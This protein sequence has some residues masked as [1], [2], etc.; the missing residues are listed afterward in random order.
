MSFFTFRSTFKFFR[1]VLFAQ[2]Y[3]RPNCSSNIYAIFSWSLPSSNTIDSKSLYFLIEQISI[4]QE[5][6]TGHRTRATFQKALCYRKIGIFQEDIPL[7][8]YPP[9]E[10]SPCRTDNIIQGNFILF[11]FNFI[12]NSYNFFHLKNTSMSNDKKCEIVK[13][14]TKP[15]ASI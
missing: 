7:S 6:F 11:F 9:V 3:G 15:S 4:F 10:I 13:M 2:F 14:L 8:R 12:K 5:A 1:E